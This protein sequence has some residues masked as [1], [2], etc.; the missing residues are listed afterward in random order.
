MWDAIIVGGGHNGLVCAAHLSR[1]N[2][3][4]LVLE[5]NQFLGGC[6]SEQAAPCGCSLSY[7]ANHFG[8]FRRSIERSLG[9]SPRRAILPDPQHIVLFDEG[10]SV[11]AWRDPEY[12][13]AELTRFSAED[14][15]SYLL[16]TKHLSELG[17]ILHRR[18]NNL[19][20]PAG[21][22]NARLRETL[23]S[24]LRPFLVGSLS[25]VVDTYFRTPIAKAF[26]GAGAVLG[27]EE[28]TAPGTAFSIAYLTL[29]DAGRRHDGGWGVIL[30]GFNSLI[31]EIATAATAAGCKI[32]MNSEVVRAECRPDGHWRVQTAAGESFAT[33]S[34][35][36]ACAPEH[37]SRVGNFRIPQTAEDP[38]ACAKIVG[39]L[40]GVPPLRTRHAAHAAAS[41][42]TMLVAGAG[43]QDMAANLKAYRNGQ[44][45]PRMYVELLFPSEI[46]STAGCGRHVTF[47]AFLM[48]VPSGGS[49]SR[50]DLKHAFLRTIGDALPEFSSNLVQMDVALPQDLD[51]R[52]GLVSSNVDHG[53]MRLG[54]QLWDR[55][56]YLRCCFPKHG[57]HFASAARHPGGLVTGMP[58]W[59]AAKEVLKAGQ[60]HA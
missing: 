42:R 3:R 17:E 4:V 55:D 56:R 31:S 44:L 35:V 52:F 2:R 10:E 19:S 23:P 26:V 43:N 24:Y 20:S 41:A 16:W 30:G 34:L 9:L 39:T 7:G 47:S 25:Q 6:S 18:I 46:D 50:E 40:S 57:L 15:R 8:M 38:G 28:P 60:E 45:A 29:Y 27:P 11:A 51:D 37:L 33:R 5:R 48:Y 59:L 1:R 22:R 54:R 32:L 14:A 36:W 49:V 12:T 58:G 13:A 21:D 53:T